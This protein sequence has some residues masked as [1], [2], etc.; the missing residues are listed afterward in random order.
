[1]KRDVSVHGSAGVI[2]TVGNHVR[3]ERDGASIA[4]DFELHPMGEGCWWVRIGVR[5]FRVV[6][7]AAGVEVFDPRDRRGGGAGAQQQGRFEMISPM[8]G[9]VI[10]VL[11]SVGDVVEVGDGVVVVEAMKMQNEMKSPQAGTVREVRVKADATVRAGEIL[12]VIE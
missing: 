12:L 2:E 4:G 6:E 7:G 8:P 5:S 11:A 9:K 1:M 3:Y 10:R